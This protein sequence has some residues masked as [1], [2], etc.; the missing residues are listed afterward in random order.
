MD[1]E[2]NLG[3]YQYNEATGE[4]K[5]FSVVEEEREF[6][7]GTKEAGIEAAKYLAKKG[8][9]IANKVRK[10]EDLLRQTGLHKFKSENFRTVPTPESDLNKALSMVRDKNSSK[11]EEILTKKEYRIAPINDKINS[12]SN[13]VRSKYNYPLDRNRKRSK[14]LGIDYQVV[15]D[16]PEG[17]LDRHVLKEMLR[18]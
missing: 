4:E 16:H 2:G 17:S 6:A 14:R 1:E 8:N 5:L 13:M 12:K 15:R 10:R 18:R 9:K 3:Y 7:R 11:A